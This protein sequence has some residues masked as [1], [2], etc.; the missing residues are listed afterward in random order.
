[1]SA[2]DETL[3]KHRRRIIEREEQA[4]RELLDAYSVIEDELRDEI[5]ALLEKMR[6]AREAGEDLSPSWLFRERRLRNLI[7]QVKRQI[8]RFGGQATRITTNEQ[9]A[10]IR[11][12]GEQ[13]GETFRLVAGQQSAVSSQLGSLLPTR[14]IEDAVGMMG[15]GAPILE[16]YRE[17]LAP[18]VAEAIR[19]EVIK[20]VATGTDF[21]TIARRL[22]QTGQITKSRALMVARTEVN[23]VRRET[24]RQTFAEIPDVTGWEWVAAKSPLTCPVCLALDGRIFPL[25]DPFPQHPNCR[26]TMIAVIDGVT[27]SDRILGKDWF[28]QQSDETKAK[29]LGQEAFEAYSRGEVKLEDFIGWKNSAQFGKSVY[30]KSLAS[31]QNKGPE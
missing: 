28:D 6:V 4:F 18:R 12:A 24:M 5:E 30:T 20:A 25:K 9:R 14:V 26:C 10:A 3:K 27:R 7:D 8:E 19:I 31:I 21:K 15:N 29:I 2:L 17:T 16:Y 22:L 23:R 11:I 1:M 13:A